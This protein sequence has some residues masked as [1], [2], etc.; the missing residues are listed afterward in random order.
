MR[1]PLGKRVTAWVLVLCLGLLFA[2]CKRG[3]EGE[4]RKMAERGVVAL[5][6][7]E[8]IFLKDLKHEMGSEEPSVVNSTAEFV[9]QNMI[10]QLLLLQDARKRGLRVPNE[11]I[12]RLAFG[13]RNATSLKERKWE[14]ELEKLWLMGKEA[15][16]VCPP[17]P[18]ADSE[19]K[20]YYQA[21][22]RDFL[23]KD[24]VLLRQIVLDNKEEAEKLRKR[25]KRKGLKEFEK[26]AKEYSIGPERAFGGRLG[27]VRKGEEPPGFD[28]VFKLKPG[29]VS[30]V[31]KTDYGYHLFFVEKRVKDW[32]LPL[33]EVKGE[34]E[35]ILISRE[36]DR[37]LKEWLANARK[38]SRIEIRKKVMSALLVEGE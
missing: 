11:L 13:N 12:S 4:D 27:L 25:L 24:G 18:P 19:I 6:N 29:R 17:K 31:V 22:R 16:T 3:R 26:A 9:L 10:D 23:V 33:E 1:L 20:E 21:H 14:R 32:Y 7:G 35:R 2:S 36:G 8:P 37:C 34:I 5:V 28:V 38:R 30:E 15:E